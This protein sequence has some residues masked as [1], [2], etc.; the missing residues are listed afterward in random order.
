MILSIFNVFNIFYKKSQTIAIAEKMC[1]NVGV[2]E[3]DD[4]ETAARRD[5]V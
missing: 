4:I 5:F 3:L 2:P 1:Y